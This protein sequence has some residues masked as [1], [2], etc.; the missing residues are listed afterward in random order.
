MYDQAVVNA[1]QMFTLWKRKA[2]NAVLLHNAD[3]VLLYKVSKCMTA[4][5]L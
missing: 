4:L 2:K 1:R 5:K 3:Q